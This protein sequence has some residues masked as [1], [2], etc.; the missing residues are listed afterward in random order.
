[1]GWIWYYWLISRTY[2]LLDGRL[3]PHLV[4]ALLYSILF[5]LLLNKIYTLLQQKHLLRKTI[6]IPLDHIVL[7]TIEIISL[8][9]SHLNKLLKDGLKTLIAL[10]VKT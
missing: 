7:K 1:M 9:E 2:D 6:T 8:F 3:V 10:R 4:R 5:S